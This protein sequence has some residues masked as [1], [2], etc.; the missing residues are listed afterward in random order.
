MVLTI[1]IGIASFLR[2]DEKR[3]R[4]FFSNWTIPTN[5]LVIENIAN[6]IIEF[7][8]HGYREF[9][10]MMGYNATRKLKSIKITR[11]AFRFV[12]TTEI[13]VMKVF[14]G[15][16]SKKTKDFER[17]FVGSWML[18]QKCTRLKLQRSATTRCCSAR[19]PF[20][21]I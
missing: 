4:L 3:Q 10:W 7:P 21:K 9:E 2:V 8:Y 15:P 11:S 18:R 17:C 12:A 20:L 1:C 16:K 14:R 6:Q 19:F 13:L 5:A